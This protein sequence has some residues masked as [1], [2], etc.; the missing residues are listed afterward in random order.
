MENL[1]EILDR[2]TAAA[3]WQRDK[4]RDAGEQAHMASSRTGDFEK[5]A[6]E[7]A[8]W[9]EGHNLGIHGSRKDAANILDSIAV[10]LA[11]V[12]GT[13]VPDA[14]EARDRLLTKTR[15]EIGVGDPMPTTP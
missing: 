3:S 8:I 9:F 11:A 1:A 6:N 15:N 2:V 12:L 10:A 4:S 7:T 13:S 14:E 5:V